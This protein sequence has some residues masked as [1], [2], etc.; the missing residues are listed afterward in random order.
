MK[1]LGWVLRLKMNVE[2]HSLKQCDLGWR[3]SKSMFFSQQF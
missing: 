2:R 1:E 3:T